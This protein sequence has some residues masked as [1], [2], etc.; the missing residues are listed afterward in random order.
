MEAQQYHFSAFRESVDKRELRL[1]WLRQRAGQLQCSY[2]GIFKTATT[3]W[4]CFADTPG[5]DGA[6]VVRSQ[7]SGGEVLYVTRY[8][9]DYVCV[10]WQADKLCCAQTM[11]LEQLQQYL[12]SAIEPDHD[13]I[14]VVLALAGNDSAYPQLASYFSSSQVTQYDQPLQAAT[15]NYALVALPKLRRLLQ[16][17]RYLL[18]SSTLIVTIALVSVLAWLRQ[19]APP[20]PDVP[21]DVQQLRLTRV[22]ATGVAVASTLPLVPVLQQLQ[23]LA[24]WHLQQLL[25]NEAKPE[26]VF[27]QVGASYGDVSHLRQQLVGLPLQWEFSKQGVILQLPLSAAAGAATLPEFGDFAAQVQ[28]LLDALSRHLPDVQL[29]LGALQSEPYG[30]ISRTVQLQLQQLYAEDL[31]TLLHILALL[32]VRLVNLELVSQHYQISGDMKLIMY[33]QGETS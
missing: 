9:G 15:S 31:E 22:G 19:P 30:L 10:H 2:V 1:Y 11:A 4:L 6:A 27:M 29:Q 7:L 12:R 28:W 16:P 17:Y 8:Q 14:E 25:L 13:S 3:N 24:G 32:P 23:G 5:I 18:W 26:V 33:A 20:V 21:V